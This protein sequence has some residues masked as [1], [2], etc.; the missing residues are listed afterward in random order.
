MDATLSTGENL[1]D[2]SG[3]AICQEYLRDFQEY[4]EDITPIRAVSFHA[5]FIY[6]AVQARQKIF[7]EA[8]NPSFRYKRFDNPP[9]FYFR[10]SWLF[11]GY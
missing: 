11:V 9:L 2:I 7:D 4:H 3:I 8:T 5:F 6:L 1:A 10:G